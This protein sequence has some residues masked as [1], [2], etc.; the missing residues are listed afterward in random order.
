MK[1]VNLLV[2]MAVQVPDDTNIEELYLDV[3]TN[4]I[5]VCDNLGKVEGSCVFEYETIDTSIVES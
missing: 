5:D 3:P 2:N 4:L 1:T